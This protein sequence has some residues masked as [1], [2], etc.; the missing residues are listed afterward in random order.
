MR[1][2][3]LTHYSF[4]Y[5]SNRSLASLINHYILQGEHV[6]VML[7][8]R[9]AFYHYLVKRGVKVH[10]FMFLYEVLYYKL[11]TKYLSLPLLWLYDILMLPLLCYKIYKIKP[12]IIYTNSTADL[13]SVWIAKFL[14]RKHIV[15]VRE[16]MEEDFGA[17]CIFGKIA[18]RNIILKSDGVICVSNAVAKSVIGTLPSNV[19]VIYNGLPHPQNDYTYPDLTKSLKIGVVGNI[20]IS[21]QQDLAISYMPIILQYYPYAE[22]HI[23]GDKDCPYKKKIKQQVQ[24]LNLDKKVIFDGFVKYVEDIYYID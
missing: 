21:K 18:K 6:E 1:I 23:I 19:K 4:L 9:G 3:F 10:H 2:L 16:F 11:N 13:I 22:L 17:R 24:D 8:S 12:D 20:D 14:K 7:P 5:G 15:H